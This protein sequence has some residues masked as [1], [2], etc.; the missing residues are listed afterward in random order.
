MQI[1]YQY[2]NRFAHLYFLRVKN[3]SLFTASLVVLLPDIIS[4][5]ARHQTD[6]PG[7]VQNDDQEKNQDDKQYR[8]QIRSDQDPSYCF[9]SIHG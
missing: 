5:V 4:L 2:A 9:Q 3:N 7:N 8:H 1:F 6:Q